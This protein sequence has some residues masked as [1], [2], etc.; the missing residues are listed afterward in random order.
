MEIR[1][2][3]EAELAALVEMQRLIFRPNEAAEAAH[4][5]YWSYIH[6][7][8][9]YR[10]DQ[11]RIVFDQGRIVAHLRVWDRCIRLRGEVLRVGGIGSVMTHPECLGQ[12][13]AS[14][15]LR[16]TEDYLLEGGYDLGMLFTIIGTAF[17]DR[18][19]WIPIALPTFVLPPAQILPMGSLEGRIRPLDASQDLL[20]VKTLYD[21]YTATM[22]GVETRPQAYWTSGPSGYRGVF[23]LWGVEVAGKLVAYCNFAVEDERIWIKEACALPAYETAYEAL[24][25]KVLT[26]VRETGKT[27]LEGSLPIGHSFIKYL[28]TAVGTRSQWGCHDEMMVKGINWQS[29]SERF[30][31]AEEVPADEAAF[32]QQLFGGGEQ[33]AAWAQTLPASVGPFY[34][35]SDIF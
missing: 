31:C 3:T 25:N 34:W 1:S 8:P 29:L 19:G 32:W 21:Q 13:Y 23:P 5:R 12:G 6:E 35:W 24:A 27:C 11:S 15:L 14:A 9:T 28:E 20:T 7:E 2:A 10:L 26:T 16:D 4:P 18:L 30:G 33:T 22:D 17:Y